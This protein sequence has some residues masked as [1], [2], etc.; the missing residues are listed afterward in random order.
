M[1]YLLMKLQSLLFVPAFLYLSGKPIT[2]SGFKAYRYY[3]KTKLIMYACLNM[4]FSQAIRQLKR[5]PQI[6]TF[7]QQSL[8][9]VSFK[10]K[11]ESG[12][13]KYD[14]QWMYQYIS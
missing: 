14:V 6:M 1:I 13:H 10:W 2:Y 11:M 9:K 5:F 7:S 12:A 4:S 3:A 8:P